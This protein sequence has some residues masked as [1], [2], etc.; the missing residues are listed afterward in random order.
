MNEYNGRSFLIKAVELVFICFKVSDW[1]IRN[2]FKICLKV[3]DWLI[4][5][6]YVLNIH[7]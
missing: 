4:Y 1:L 3:T 6:N 5:L 7:L 2:N